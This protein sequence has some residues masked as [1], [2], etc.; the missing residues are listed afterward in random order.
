MERYFLAEQTSMKSGF[1]QLGSLLVAHIYHHI[2]GLDA[3]HAFINPFVEL[4]K[5]QNCPEQI[6]GTEDC[7]HA[8]TREDPKGAKNM[9]QLNSFFLRYLLHHTTI[10][11]QQVLYYVDCAGIIYIEISTRLHNDHLSLTLHQ[12]NVVSF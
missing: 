3:L 1:S 4:K 7:I 9:R 12:Q 6:K 8:G 11:E 5:T 2:Y 10:I